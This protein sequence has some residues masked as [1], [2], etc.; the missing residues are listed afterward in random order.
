MHAGTKLDGGELVTS[1]GRVLGLTGTGPTLKAALD[2]AY[3]LCETVSFKGG[4]YRKDIAHRE[5]ERQK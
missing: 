5:L 3:K 2:T 4:F 1:G